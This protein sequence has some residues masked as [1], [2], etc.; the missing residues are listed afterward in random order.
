MKK[1]RFGIINEEIQTHK[2]S[3]NKPTELAAGAV[4]HPDR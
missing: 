4:A 1:D 2:M 3:F